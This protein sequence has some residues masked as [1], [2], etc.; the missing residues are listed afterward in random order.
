MKNFGIGL[1]IGLAGLAIWMVSSIV[2]GTVE[3]FEETQP[4]FGEPLMFIGFAI[5][6][7]GPIT[8]WIILPIVKLFR[9]RRQ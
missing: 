1:G 3:A 6:L 2:A 5:M 8:F 4:W 7:L 9:R